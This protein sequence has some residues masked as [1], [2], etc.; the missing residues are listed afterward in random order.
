MVKLF[1]DDV[2][3]APSEDWTTAKSSK[4]AIE[5]IKENGI[6]DI[7][8]FDHDLGGDDTSV[9]IVNEMIEMILDN[10][11]Y[12][13][14]ENFRFFVHSDNPV[15]SENIKNTLTNF[16]RFKFDKNYPHSVIRLKNGEQ[17]F[18]LNKN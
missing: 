11:D 4:E 9:K 10:D 16:Y 1:I 13:F 12:S 14:S 17:D 7:I 3:F 18:Y 15:G 5:F 6:P 2:R 8:S